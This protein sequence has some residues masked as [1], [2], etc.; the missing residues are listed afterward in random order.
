MSELPKQDVA[1]DEELAEAG[2]ARALE[3]WRS[4]RSPS[5]R[6]SPM[7]GLFSA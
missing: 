6:L 5:P 4:R 3:P 1:R 2:L 7:H